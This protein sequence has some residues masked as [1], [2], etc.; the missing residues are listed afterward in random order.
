MKMIIEKK[1]KMVEIVVL[2]KHLSSFWRTLG[3]P[4]VNFE[5]NLVLTWPEIYILT[6]I[7]AAV[8]TQASNL[9]RPAINAPTGA[10]F[11]ISDIK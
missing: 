4:L 8:P 7:G 6:D 1:H 5:I 11:K 2:L 3:I 10:T 9:A